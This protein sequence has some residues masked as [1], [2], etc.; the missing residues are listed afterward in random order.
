MIPSAVRQDLLAG[1][2]ATGEGL[3]TDCA[4][5]NCSLDTC[6]PG[7]CPDCTALRKSESLETGMEATDLSPEVKAP[8]RLSSADFGAAWKPL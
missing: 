6:T 7:N 1:D 2:G 4:S 5:G 8:E 3:S